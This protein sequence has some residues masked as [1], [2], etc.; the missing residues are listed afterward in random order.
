MIDLQDILLGGILPAVV[1]AGVLLLECWLSRRSDAHSPSN[2]QVLWPLAAGG[3]YLLGHSLQHD[4]DWLQP[5][6]AIDWLP[7]IALA[8]AAIGVLLCLR[9]TVKLAAS[10]VP[11]AGVTVA[12][13]YLVLKPRIEHAWTNSEAAAWVVL[14]GL[15]IAGAWAMLA[16]SGGTSGDSS[17]SSIAIWEK[18][19]AWLLVAIAGGLTLLF[20]GTQRY[21]EMAGTLIFVTIALLIVAAWKKGASLLPASLGVLIVPFGVLLVAGSQYASLTRTNLFLLAAALLLATAPLPG[22]E[23]LPPLLRWL[24][25]LLAVAVPLGIV[26]TVSGIQF[27]EDLANPSPY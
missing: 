4:L 6:E 19:V 15:V 24:I 3:G 16:R 22:R 5:A 17:P 20:S 23:K 1:V 26:L 11:T 18:S 12:G 25:R 2:W 21:G 7:G 13:L 27:A 9:R 10:A 8:A 14:P